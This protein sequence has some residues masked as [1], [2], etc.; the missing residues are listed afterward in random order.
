[1]ANI[2]KCCI[3]GQNRIL[4]KEH[5][6]PQS[7]YNKQKTYLLGAKE[8]FG[9]DWLPPWKLS[10]KGGRQYQ[11]GVFFETL[12]GKCNNFSGG[13]YGKAFL[14]FA[15]QGFSYLKRIEE[16]HLA[17]KIKINFYKIHPLKILKQIIAMF[18][19]INSPDF[20]T[21][22]EEL[23]KFVLNNEKIGLPDQNYGLYLYFLT[24]TIGRYVGIQGILNIKRGES[25]IISELS[26]PPFGF[27]LELN[28][29]KTDY[30]CNINFFSKFKYN[31]EKNLSLKIPVLE[32]NTPYPGDYRT[33]QRI[34]DDYIKGKILSKN[35]AKANKR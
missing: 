2:G 28:P 13:C 25:R 35:D 31:E 6:P 1:M 26:H 5:V 15:T 8:M 27:V 22:E 4:T 32:S 29:K 11:G 10:L 3:C 16:D 14:D 23:R 24:G 19:S 30:Y 20:F 9:K 34:F 21:A 33:K 7:A 18:A 17:G 12:C